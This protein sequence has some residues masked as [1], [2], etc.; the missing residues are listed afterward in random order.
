M[1][2]HSHIQSDKQKGRTVLDC[3]SG[4]IR[5]CGEAIDKREEKEKRMGRVIMRKE[6]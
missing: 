6:I 5:Q 2:E 1:V 3:M 4:K